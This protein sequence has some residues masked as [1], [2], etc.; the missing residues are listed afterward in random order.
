MTSRNR[1]RADMN[2]M[3]KIPEGRGKCDSTIF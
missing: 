3:M 2:D 1:N